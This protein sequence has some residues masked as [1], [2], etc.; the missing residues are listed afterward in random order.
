MSYESALAV[1]L[2]WR[3]VTVVGDLIVAALAFANRRGRAG[4][5]T[6]DVKSPIPNG[7]PGSLVRRITRGH[8]MIVC[9]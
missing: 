6:E 7:E 2:V 9:G 8:A 1:T 3:A 4:R 5:T